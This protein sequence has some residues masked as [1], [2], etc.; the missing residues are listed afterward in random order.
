M[1][2]I[3]LIDNFDS[4]TYNILHGLTEAG[5]SVVVR[6][7]NELDLAA[8]EAFGPSMIV[9]SPGPGRP[10]DAGVCLDVARQLAGRRSS[11]SCSS[12]RNK[13]GPKIQRF[14]LM[15]R[16]CGLYSGTIPFDE[17]WRIGKAAGSGAAR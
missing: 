9:L 12:R 7:R 14:V 8:V 10:E 11:R 5:A 1:A 2:P 4:F 15:L 3:L 17:T 6:G 16:R 13:T